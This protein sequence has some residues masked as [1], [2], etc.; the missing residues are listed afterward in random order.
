MKFFSLF[1][2][3]F[4]SYS[5]L[6]DVFTEGFYIEKKTKKGKWVIT[7]ERMRQKDTTK[8]IENMVL[9]I[10]RDEELI[11]VKGKMAFYEKGKGIR[12]E[13]GS[14]NLWDR[15]I[16]GKE[17]IWK[18]GEEVIILNLPFIVEC[19]K[20]ILKGGSGEI[21]LENKVIRIKRGVEWIK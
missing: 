16:R 15:V 6:G 5:L 19:K 7:G 9:K 13:E 14:I 21:D 12:V 11:S 18:E 8:E 10:W 2:I 4:F 1:V 3:S 17:F 20:W